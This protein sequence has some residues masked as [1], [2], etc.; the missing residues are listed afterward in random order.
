[1]AN[2]LDGTFFVITLPAPIV[3]LE[4]IVKGATIEVLEP[5]KTLSFIIVLF[6]FFPS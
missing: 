6:F 2:V 3:E 1:M 4:P 5:T